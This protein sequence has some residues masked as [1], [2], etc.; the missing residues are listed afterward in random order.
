M[1]CFIISNGTKL[2]WVIWEKAG[3]KDFL[4]GGFT[5]SLK[6]SET[7]CNSWLSRLPCRL[8]RQNNFVIYIMVGAAHSVFPC[9]VAR[10]SFPVRANLCNWWRDLENGRIAS[11]Q[12]A[13]KLFLS[14]NLG[15]GRVLV[16]FIWRGWVRFV[17][18]FFNNIFVMFL[19]SEQMFAQCCMNKPAH[20]RLAWR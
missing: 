12:M 14:I 1:M 7:F 6:D 3:L 17:L 16:L 8:F 9:K 20:L 13:W 10:C 4:N 11:A 18:S 15:V 2:K 5:I 19:D